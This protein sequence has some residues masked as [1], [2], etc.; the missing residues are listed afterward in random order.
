MK[1]SKLSRN[2]LKV[3][4]E[5]KTLSRE[6]LR[7]IIRNYYSVY[8]QDEV[9]SS[10]DKQILE[11]RERGKVYISSGDEVRLTKRGQ[12]HY[13]QLLAIRRRRQEGRKRNSLTKRKGSNTRSVHEEIKDKVVEL[14]KLLGKECRNEYR[15]VQGVILDTVWYENNADTTSISHAFE[16]QNNGDI[17]NAICN[18][19]ITRRHHPNC[20]LYLVTN[21]EE[22]YIGAVRLL[23]L[24]KS[25]SINVVLAKD[26][27]GCSDDLTKASQKLSPSCYDAIKKVIDVLAS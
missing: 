1:N 17:K 12:A 15:L 11:L 13:E 14:G 18:L 26:I 27:L 24:E 6:E 22:D 23:G 19:Y 4:G 16:V 21:D 7:Y 3:L 2:I 25:E 5:K 20:R 8:R 9:Y 10:F